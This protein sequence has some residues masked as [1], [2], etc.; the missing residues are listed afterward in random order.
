M[1]RL[2]SSYGKL[3][4]G[5]QGFAVFVL[6]ATMAVGLRGQAADGGLYGTTIGGGADL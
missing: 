4:R 6:C 3:N 5:N 1:K 2:V